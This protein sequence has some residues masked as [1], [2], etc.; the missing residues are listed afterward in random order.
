MA[1]L[2]KLQVATLPDA[3]LDRR[4]A[5]PALIERPEDFLIVAGLAGTAQELS[6]MTNESPGVFG[7]GGAMGA[8][9]MMGLGLA[10]AQPKRRVLVVTGDG[11]LL[12]NLGALATIALQNPP[13]LTVICVDNGHY[14]ET[15]NQDSHTGLG[16]ALDRIA[17]GAG[18][19]VVHTINTEADL[20]EGRRLLR[21]GSGLAF[22]LLR[23]KEGPANKIKRNLVP[24]VERDR[25]R[26]ALLGV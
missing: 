15:G 9:P 11:E 1:K 12:M 23:V 18:F 6:A 5:V 4:Q 3:V 8:A 7:L 13:N 24:H 21:E 22:I 26:R 10:L 19:P 20:A 17:A 2:N 16:V 25:F 14:G